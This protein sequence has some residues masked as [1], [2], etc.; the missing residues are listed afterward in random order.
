MTD[1]LDEAT[2]ERRSM[3]E[4]L[5]DLRAK[6][7]KRPTAELARMIQQ[8]EAEIAIRKRQQSVIA[9]L[10]LGRLEVF[11][12][13]YRDAAGPIIYGPFGFSAAAMWQIK[14]ASGHAAVRAGRTRDVISITRAPS[15]KAAAGW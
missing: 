5:A 1:D 10:S 11:G 6:Y 8:L 7:E 12:R 9:W 15:F 14:V 2:R 3:E 13:V 4:A